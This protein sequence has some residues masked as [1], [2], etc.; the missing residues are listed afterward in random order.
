[1]TKKGLKMPVEVKGLV[2]TQK[3]L[4]QLAPDLYK[5]MN[6]EIRVALKVIVKDAQSNVT[7]NVI[8][9]YNWQDR[10][11]P[12]VSR[13]KAKTPLAPNLR[14]F[15]KYNPVV[16]KKGL[17][18]SLARGKRNSAGFVS[19]YRLLNKSAAGAIIE[20][21][22]RK[23]FNGSNQS[24]SNNPNAG[25]HFNRSIQGTYGG[26]KS[27]GKRP[28]DRGRLLY[29]A[30]ARDEGRVT[31]AVFKAIYKAESNFRNRLRLAA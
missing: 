30:F 18:Y 20:T 8:G 2:E 17:T 16:I 28:Q 4:K 23:N 5:E 6:K 13:T 24:R 27:I 31:D 12:V 3:A 11:K 1:M 19:F 21:A 29:A 9:L 22:G 7:P 26:F 15:P 14:A 25:A 10:N